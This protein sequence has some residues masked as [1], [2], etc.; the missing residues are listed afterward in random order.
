[1]RPKPTPPRPR[2]RGAA[3]PACR[4]GCVDARPARSPADR[5]GRGRRSRPPVRNGQLVCRD[6]TPEERQTLDRSTTAVPLHVISP[7][8]ALSARAAGL[9]LT[10]R[11]TEQLEANPEAKAAFLKAADIWMSKISTPVTVIIDVDYGTTALRHPV[12]GERH[13]LH[14][15]PGPRRG[16]SLPRPRRRAEGPPVGDAFLPG[17]PAAHRP[18]L[19]PGR[20]RPER[21][22]PG[23]RLHRP[24][25]GPGQGVRLGE[26]AQ[27]RLQLGHPL[28]L[29][30][31]RRDQPGPVRLRVDRGARDRARPRLLL[32]CG[33]HRV[34]FDRLSQLLRLGPLPLPSGRDRPDVSQRQPDSLFRRRAGLLRRGDLARALDRPARRHRRRRIPVEPLE[35]RRADRDVHRHHGPV[36]RSRGE[37][38][39]HAERPPGPRGHGLDDRVRIRD[40]LLLD[41]PLFRE[42]PGPGRRLLHDGPLHREPRGGRGPIHDEVP[43]TRRRRH[44]RAEVARVHPRLEPVGHLRGRPRLGLRPAGPLLR[45]DPGQRERLDARRP[46]PDVRRPSSPTGRAASPP[47]RSGSRSRPSRRPT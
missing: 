32:L 8:K 16:R 15:V 38:R 18:R 28:R 43:R 35:G 10:L 40:A 26:P 42:V 14:E 9:T 21:P 12:R 5:L 27:D 33:L 20:L 29:Q 45:S 6:A 11:A 39:D 25:R 4:R 34:R 36:D 46:R 41:P 47:A 23:D 13:R 17:Q 7:L 1:M 37:G 2:P 22:P 24:G 44:E 3:L 31:G 30:P 19:D